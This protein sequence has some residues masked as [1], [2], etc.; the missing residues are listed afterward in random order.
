MADGKPGE[1]LV[2]FISGH[3]KKIRGNWHGDSVWAHFRKESGGMVHVNKAEVEYM[4][5]FEDPV[6]SKK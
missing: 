5:T 6:S 3:Y 4:E 1:T 2:C